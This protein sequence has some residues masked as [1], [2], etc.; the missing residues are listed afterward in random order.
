M[1]KRFVCLCDCLSARQPSCLHIF[2][3]AWLTVCFF[4]C[5]HLSESCQSLIHMTV[6]D[7]CLRICLS[8]CLCLSL[9]LPA[10]L[11]V[12]LAI[13]LFSVYLFPGGSH[14]VLHTSP[15]YVCLCMYLS[16]WVS[17][18]LSP[19]LLACPIVCLSVFCLFIC[20]NQS[21]FATHVSLRYLPV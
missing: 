5:I 3:S 6:N 15:S 19:H 17:V 14:S 12:R 2:L 16:V 18:Y 13:Y 20:I 21:A 11:S 7:V 8:I 9:C 1:Y 10:S 4:L